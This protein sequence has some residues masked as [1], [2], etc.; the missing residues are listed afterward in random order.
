MNKREAA[1]ISAYTGYLIGTFTE[2]QK[3]AEEITGTEPG[4]F[5]TMGMM[6]SADRIKELAEDDF[7]KLSEGLTE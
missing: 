5:T 3:Y 4:T 6:V 2:L 7:A 1:I